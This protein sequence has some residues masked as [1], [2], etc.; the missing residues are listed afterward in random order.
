MLYVYVI[1]SCGS[2]DFSGFYCLLY[3]VCGY[4]KG[5][6]KSH[7]V[8]YPVYFSVFFLYFM[9]CNVGELLVESSCY[10]LCGSF[11][12]VVE[13]DCSVCLL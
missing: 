12:F 5:W 9:F 3:L 1:G 7:F 6:I 13:G 8:S 11:R 2:V 10:V 4:G